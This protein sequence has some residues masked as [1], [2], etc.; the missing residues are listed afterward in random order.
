MDDRERCLYIAL[1]GGQP[2][3]ILLGLLHLAGGTGPARPTDALLIGTSAV[4]KQMRNLREILPMTAARAMDGRD[5]PLLPERQIDDAYDAESARRIVAEAIAAFPGTRIVL[6]LNGGTAMMALGA[7]TAARQVVRRE[8]SRRIMLQYVVTAD[9]SFRYCELPRGA[10]HKVGFPSV[11]AGL[12]LETLCAA[13]GVKLVLEPDRHPAWNKPASRF[14]N[15]P[16]LLDV[17]RKIKQCNFTYQPTS[18]IDEANNRQNSGLALQQRPETYKPPDN[19]VGRFCEELAAVGL[20]KREGRGYVVPPSKDVCDFW[21]GQWLERAI[22]GSLLPLQ[23]ANLLASRDDGGLLLNVRIEA[24]KDEIDVAALFMGQLLIVECKDWSFGHQVA[25]RQV[26][27]FKRALDRLGELRKQVGTFSR[28]YMATTQLPEAREEIVR[29]CREF[30]ITLIELARLPAALE[31]R[32][33]LRP[34]LRS[35]ITPFR[36]TLTCWFATEL[37][38]LRVQSHAP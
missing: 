7:Y 12:S 27:E 21:R 10:W 9:R 34:E 1:V 23:E 11:F 14:A 8:E 24:Q 18:F 25:P 17:A 30:G 19:T 2:A 22:Y 28:A 3:P 4:R 6:N 15:E 20:L 26:A 33:A 37:Q 36:G 29:R 32:L 38:M 31:R 13:Y 35:A 16:A 5:M